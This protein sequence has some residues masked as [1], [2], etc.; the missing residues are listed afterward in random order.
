MR[1]ILPADSY[2]VYNRGIIGEDKK[3]VLT[4]LYQPII[5]ISAVSLYLT[6]LNDLN[7][8]E[9][10]S[11]ILTHHHLMSNMQLNLETILKAR[12]KLEAIGLMKT[13]YKED[14]INSYLYLLYSPISANE[15]LNHP[16]LNGVLYNNVG[17]MEYDN[18]VEKFKNSRISTKDYV[19]IT[20]AFSDIFTSVNGYS[21]ENKDILT[22]RTRKLEI[23][24]NIDINRSASI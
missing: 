20:S 17:K 22:D 4:T 14:N 9:N 15:F 5:G 2:K 24:S 3:R 16:I 11:D 10:E 19:D 21:I 23:N 6:F 12:E 13:Y 18:I 8:G 1:T 7:K